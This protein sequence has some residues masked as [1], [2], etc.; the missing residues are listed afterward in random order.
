MYCCFMLQL[1]YIASCVYIISSSTPLCNV[2][3][4]PKR[5]G[6]VE[7]RYITT[8]TPIRTSSRK[9]ENIKRLSIMVHEMRAVVPKVR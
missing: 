5:I 6:M 3:R 4:N 9:S 8:S 7:N 2:Y 1:D